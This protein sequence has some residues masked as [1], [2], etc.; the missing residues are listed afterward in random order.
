MLRTWT[1]RGVAHRHEGPLAVLP[2]RRQH[3]GDLRVEQQRHGLAGLVPCHSGSAVLLRCCCLSSWPACGFRLED[4]PMTAVPSQ[5]TNASSS[6]RLPIVQTGPLCDQPV[7]GVSHR[8]TQS[9]S[10]P[11][12]HQPG[13]APAPLKHANRECICASLALA[14]A[15]LALALDAGGDNGELRENQKEESRRGFPSALCR[16]LANSALSDLF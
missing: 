13:K 9:S 8:D 7:F 5:D 3:A 12:E 11:G 1:H 14:R 2:H 10:T 6:Q 4:A 15:W 16:S